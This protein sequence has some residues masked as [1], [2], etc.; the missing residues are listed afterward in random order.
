MMKQRK[1]KLVVNSGREGLRA[2][3]EADAKLVVGGRANIPKSDNGDC[4]D[5]D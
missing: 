1:P 3:T 5:R 4:Y 2:L